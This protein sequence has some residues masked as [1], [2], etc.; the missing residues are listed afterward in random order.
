MVSQT[1]ILLH[2]PSHSADSHHPGA[3]PTDTHPPTSKL[4]H[5]GALRRQVLAGWTPGT[6]FWV[7]A[8]AS[9]IWNPGFDSPER[10]PARLHGYHRALKMWSRVHRGSPENP[11][12]VCALLPGGSCQGMVLRLPA[13]GLEAVFDALWQREMP[14]LSY[15]PR[16][17]RCF[18]AQG[19][20]RALAFTLAPHSPSYAGSLHPE[21]YRQIFA[22]ARGCSGS[23]ADYLRHT[24]DSLRA[25]GVLDAQLVRLLA[26]TE[27]NT[28]GDAASQWL[29]CLLYTSPSPRDCS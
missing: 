12:L 7:F 16:W 17:L 29:P 1:A 9:L 20:V 8:Y 23:C 22:Q 28:A 25:L 6:D 10:R 15:Q 19:P 18:T 21:Q 13:Q 2:K 11:G 14:T 26:L 4:H 24:H 5:D 27:T 3:Y